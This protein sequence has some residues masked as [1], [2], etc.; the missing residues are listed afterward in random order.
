MA[1]VKG[2]K[3]GRPGKWVADYRDGAGVRHW[4]TFATKL[5]AEEFLDHERPRARR[6][7]VRATLSR[8][9]S[10][11][12]YAAHWLA[13]AVD[14]RPALKPSTKAIYRN[15]IERFWVPRIGH[16]QVQRLAS[17]TITDILTREL[18]GVTAHERAAALAKKKAPN[19]VR[20]YVATLTKMLGRAVRKDRLLNDNP[21]AALAEEL[22]L[23]RDPR[24]TEDVLAFD[25][26]E[27]ARFLDAALKHTPAYAGIFFLMSRTGLRPSEA[28]ALQWADYDPTRQVLLIRR[29]FGHR[30]ELGTPKTPH[31]R[32]DVDVS[33]QLAD[34]LKR[35]RKAQTEAKLAG[36]L[37][38]LPTF[39]FTEPEGSP[40][41]RR[42][43]E[44][45]F[46]RVLIKAGL[47]LHHSPKSLRHTFASILISEGKN[48]LYVLRQ[49]GHASVAITERVYTRWIP[50]P[51]P[52]V[53]SLDDAPD[54]AAGPAGSKTAGFGSSVRANLA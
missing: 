18:T 37:A 30:D 1:I 32:R 49:M 48:L 45:A 5:E 13:V 51:I 17:E 23:K 4:R 53:H 27:R 52:A 28:R 38:E 22:G 7:T 31:S 19:T 9:I 25:R 54:T 41:A 3:R 2:E 6:Q 10:I 44:R 35:H 39:I 15:V 50:Q 29:T 14:P 16:I 46:E 47:G 21:A 36:R 20:L 34:L 26:P 43:F 8:R 42:T 11:K 40:L 12:D 24:A 33:P